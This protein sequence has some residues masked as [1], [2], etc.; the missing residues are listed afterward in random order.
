MRKIIIG[1]A[2]FALAIMALPNTA[3][4]GGCYYPRTASEII[5]SSP[6]KI[7]FEKTYALPL[8]GYW[9]D[10][11][12]MFSSDNGKA[13]YINSYNRGGST[14]A[15]GEYSLSNNA[16]WPKTSA[17]DPLKIN[18]KNAVNKVGLYLGNGEGSEPV[19]AVVSLFN[20]SGEKL[21]DI[22]VDVKSDN[23][24]TF[25]GFETV[26]DLYSMTID[27]GNT[28]LSEEIDDLMFTYSSKYDPICS[29]TDDG[30]DYYVK[31]ETT[32]HW[33]CVEDG[34]PIVTEKDVCVDANTV[35]E[36]MCNSGCNNILATDVKCPNGCVNGA[37]VSPSDIVVPTLSNFVAYDTIS[38][39]GLVENKVGYKK[40]GSYSKPLPVSIYNSTKAIKLSLMLKNSNDNFTYAYVWNNNPS[41]GVEA[42][43]S[44]QTVKSMAGS[45]NF[46]SSA[47]TTLNLTDYYRGKYVMVHAFVRNND[48]KSEVPNMSVEVDEVVPLYF[49][50]EKLK[51]PT[52]NSCVDSDNGLEIY[53]KGSTK[54][55]KEGTRVYGI[56]N[57]SCSN[58]VGESGLYSGKWVVEQHCSG[59][60]DKP[61]VHT[62]WNDCPNG[63]M[64]GKCAEKTVYDNTIKP[65]VAYPTNKQVLTNYPRVATLKWNSISEAVSYNIE[66]TCDH[67]NSVAWQ[68]YYKWTSKSN[69]YVTTPL[70]GDN[71]FR[72]KVKAVYA[73]G[74]TS[75]W[76]DYRYFSYNTSAYSESVCSD[77]DGN[78][79]NVK[80]YSN[81]LNKVT[82]KPMNYVDSCVVSDTNTVYAY[83]SNYVNEWVCT[84]GNIVDSRVSKCKNGCVDGLCVEDSEVNYDISGTRV[85]FY[86]S[87]NQ[88]MKHKESGVNIKLNYFDDKRILV[89]LDGGAYFDETV[90]SLKTKTQ[91]SLINDSVN[92]IAFTYLGKTADGK[93]AKILLDYGADTN[94][95]EYGADCNL[96]VYTKGDQTGGDGVYRLYGSDKLYHSVSG[97][98]MSADPLEK[99]AKIYLALKGAKVSNVLIS[100]S[101]MKSFT[102]ANEKYNLTVTYNGSD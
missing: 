75:Q 61:Y 62:Q 26:A 82:N 34:Y 18:F 49:R 92:K 55:E 97:I 11:G 58:K 19:V 57:D 12:V 6:T 50:I 40:Y 56:Y 27:Y 38:G 21:C 65:T 86:I 99:S 67:C 71:E 41:D 48:G 52:V 7:N 51:T 5:A 17:N 83:S 23:V 94:L 100:A 14:T 8:T 68:D 78:N 98:T 45:A 36:Y 87:L 102:S 42:D 9:S 47:V 20:K 1:V 80:G 53:T 44:E 69:Y 3:S 10:N 66:L 60:V 15:S 84:A 54:G 81:G 16:T 88:T 95:N 24:D 96:K 43:Y 101:S 63:C 4:A 13:I 90:L 59:P 30:E 22:D 79:T 70:D 35:R 25:L 64:D 74:S 31:G 33:L 89:N 93:Q 46:N 77:P 28:T 73:D 32:G 2:V 85:V 37:C 76:S 39:I 72:F 91:F 29:E